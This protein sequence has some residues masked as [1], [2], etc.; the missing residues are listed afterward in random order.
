MQGQAAIMALRLNKTKKLMITPSEQ[1]ST[2]SHG[3]VE[4]KTLFLH[5]I[6]HVE[7]RIKNDIS[8]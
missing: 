7:N 1:R 3:V 6:T 5:Y 2:E 4:K 8:T